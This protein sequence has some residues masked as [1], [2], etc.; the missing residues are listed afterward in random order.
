MIFV[1]LLSVDLL[2]SFLN[3]IDCFFFPN[4]GR[5][6]IHSIDIQFKK[7]LL[8]AYYILGTFL[9]PERLITKQNL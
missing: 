3:K 7:Y 8:Q 6:Y 5:G 4:G 1:F 9:G 2:L